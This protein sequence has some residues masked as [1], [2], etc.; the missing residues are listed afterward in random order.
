M[1]K[2]NLSEISR[3]LF[4]WPKCSQSERSRSLATKK[5][6]NN[7][8]ASARRALVFAVA[9]I[10]SACSPLSRPGT[11]GLSL[12]PHPAGQESQLTTPAPASITVD[13]AQDIHTI[14]TIETP[15]KPFTPP[16]SIAAGVKLDF[17]QVAITEFVQVI[18]ESLGLNYVIDSSISGTVTVHTGQTLSGPQLYAAF[19]EIL[20][21]QGLDIRNEG[22]ISVVYPVKGVKKRYDLEGLHVRLLSVANAPVSVLTSQIQQALTSI[23]SN[24]EAVTVVPLEQL[25]SIMLLASDSSIVDTVSR[26]V[27]DLD[28]IPA[29]SRQGVYL[30]NVRC[31]LASELSKLVNSLLYSESQS[32]LPVS[33]PTTTKESTKSAAVPAS[34]P[35]T[36]TTSPILIPDDTRNVLLIRANASEHSR[37]IRLLEQLDVVPRQVMIDVLVAEVT[38]GDSLDFGVEWALKNNTLNISGSSYKQTGIQAFSNVVP[39]VV[40]GGFAYTILNG[41]SDPVAVVNALASQTDVSLISSPQIFVENNKEAIVNVG[42]R[43]PVVTSE[44][45]RTGTDQPTTDRQVQYFDTGTILKVTP[46]IHFDGMVSLNVSQQVSQATANQTSS[47]NSPVIST[48]EIKTQLSVRDG[49]PIMLGGLIS[50]GDTKTENRVPVLGNLPGIGWLFR[51]NGSQQKRTELL[52]MITPHV[53]YADGLDAYQATYRPTVKDLESRL[54]RPATM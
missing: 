6:A 7:R 47:I 23:D 48:R 46:R 51:Y 26:W 39:S 30:Y 8:S 12:A 22:T 53:V 43:V 2:P 42:D 32:S 50:R 25:Q 14:Q 35:L 45:D 49:Q 44:T 40:N 3:S 20:Q 16:A 33:A 24:H 15:A 5:G 18:A 38:L 4:W 11:T 36:N 21:V 17:D 54:G 28:T 9:M 1:T 19:Q 27:R 29:E 37:T 13:A 34:Q 52:V 10:G 41:V 31:G